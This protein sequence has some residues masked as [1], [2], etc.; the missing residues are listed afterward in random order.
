MPAAP[1]FNGPQDRIT[2][3]AATTSRVA[4]AIRT[5]RPRTAVLVDHALEELYPALANELNPDRTPVTRQPVLGHDFSEIVPRPMV[6]HFA[7]LKLL[8]VRVLFGMLNVEIFD[9]D[10]LLFRHDFVFKVFLRHVRKE[11]LAPRT[12]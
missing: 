11:S 8:I 4:R 6:D 5:M 9:R 3:D 12:F 10:A 1:A 2:A 7:D